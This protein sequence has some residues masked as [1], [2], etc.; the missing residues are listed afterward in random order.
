VNHLF[1][2]LWVTDFDALRAK[3]ASIGQFVAFAVTGFSVL[4]NYTARCE[5][6]AIR[7]AHRIIALFALNAPEPKK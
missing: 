5:H 4:A 3:L 6:Q 2:L 1:H 7:R